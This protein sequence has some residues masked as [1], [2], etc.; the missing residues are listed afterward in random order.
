MEAEV[1]CRNLRA[2]VEYVRSRADQEGVEALVRAAQAVEP[3]ITE[4]LLSDDTAWVSAR[5]FRIVLET[6]CRVLEDHD[7]P[8]KIGAHYVKSLSI[9]LMAPV[10]RAARTPELFFGRLPD[11][12]AR[13]NRIFSISVTAMSDR[14]ALVRHNF[15]KD[16]AAYS[17]KRACDFTAGA[18]ATV[19]EFY[20]GPT[21]TVKEVQ[22]VTRGDPYCEYL[23]QWKP[24]KGFLGKLLSP[25]RT[26]SSLLDE[27]TNAL[28]AAMERL[29]KR[30][31]ELEAQRRKEEQI[32]RRFQ[33]YVPYQVV[34]RVVGTEE[35]RTELISGDK[36]VVTAM[37]ADIRD[38]VGLTESIPAEEVVQTLNR[39]F[40]MTTRVIQEHRGTIDKFIG[41]AM[42]AIFGAPGSYGNDAD[43]A[44][45]AA[46]RIK[47]EME[48]FNR[49]QER[50][51]LRELQVGICLATGNAVAGNI[52]SELRWDYTVIGAPINLASRL[53]GF[54][55]KLGTVVLADSA[56]CLAL[57]SCVEAELL[58]ESS[59][60]GLTMPVMVH[61]VERLQ[62]QRRFLRYAV[63]LPAYTSAT[64]GQIED[65][66]LGGL[67]L[68]HP[69]PIE[70]GQPVRLTFTL[71][72]R[73][74]S[75][76]GVVRR[77]SET[78]DGVRLGIQIP[79]STADFDADFERFAAGHEPM[80]G[81][82]L[83]D[84]SGSGP[85]TPQ[86]TLPYFKK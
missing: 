35:A 13:F 83:S 21:A 27:T 47:Q 80:P 37:M 64:A 2:A 56:T 41:D 8:R 14:S 43:R 73:E 67:S 9:G 3:S 29:E 74:L 69:H 24:Q 19:P 15:V 11:N 34:A 1:S 40:S 49:E 30:G 16:I 63:N 60:R 22:C 26:N 17:D 76:D 65:I 36:R 52:G 78:D 25:R 55:K 4:E 39:F 32:R 85:L 12:V 31:H 59:V 20:D 28:V 50:L 62:E 75:C 46:L 66:G 79:Q 57:R 71:L 38:F 48:A 18:Y 10:F 7:A 68:A 84:P 33:Q 23:V 77:V 53:Q 44:V 51:G 86:N 81:K 45:Q 70:E 54:A 6:A 82:E 72:D 42:L 58:R 61:R 5:V